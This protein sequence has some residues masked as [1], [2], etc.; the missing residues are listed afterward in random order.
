ME[1]ITGKKAV[2]VFYFSEAKTKLHSFC[3]IMLYQYS[4]RWGACQ[5]N[6]A[7]VFRASFC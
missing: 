7:V 5:M 6:R 2:F 4:E 1:Q 3:N